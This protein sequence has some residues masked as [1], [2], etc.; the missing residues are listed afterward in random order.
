MGPEDKIHFGLLAN[1]KLY[2]QH[3]NEIYQNYCGPSTIFD[4][5]GS[6]SHC[7]D[8]ADYEKVAQKYK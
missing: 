8:G 2:D 6:K 1:K 4:Y 5:E 7:K 3:H